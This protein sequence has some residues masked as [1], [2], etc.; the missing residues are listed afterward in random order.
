M[1]FTIPFIILL[2]FILIGGVLLGGVF[3]LVLVPLAIL[4]TVGAVGGALWVRSSQDTSKSA[5]QTTP[6]DLPHTSHQN[7]APAPSTPN[8]LVDARQRQ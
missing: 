4:G 1:W 8:D 3:T 2:V 6:D 7:T 5:P